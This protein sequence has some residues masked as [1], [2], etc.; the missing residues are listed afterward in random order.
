GDS[1]RVWNPLTASYEERTTITDPLTGQKRPVIGVSV[2]YASAIGAGGWALLLPNW[3]EDLNTLRSIPDTVD[4]FTG[5]FIEV[6]VFA[7][8]VP[9]NPLDRPYENHGTAHVRNITLPATYNHVVVPLTHVLP[10]DE[11][12]RDWIDAY[13]PDGH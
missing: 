13:V 9:G 6:D 5:Y 1:L 10:R 12:T 7:L 8:S 4:E 3:W 2:A 11:K